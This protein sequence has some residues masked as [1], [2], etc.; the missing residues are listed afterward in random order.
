VKDGLIEVE[1]PEA[2][3]LNGFFPKA[4]RFLRNTAL[5]SLY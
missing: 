5:K 2:E 1:N 3:K 4:G